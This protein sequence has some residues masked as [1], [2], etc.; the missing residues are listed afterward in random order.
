MYAEHLS[1]LSLGAI[2]AGDPHRHMDLPIFDSTSGTPVLESQDFLIGEAD[3]GGLR[4]L[5]CITVDSRNIWLRY[6]GVHRMG[7]GKSYLSGSRTASILMD[8][9]SATQ[10]RFR[11]PAIDLASTSLLLYC[12]IHLCIPPEALNS[13][14]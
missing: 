5:A 9:R 10:S 14:L 7:E 8:L 2:D 12:C 1:F 13:A 3:G 4:F 11:S 6:V